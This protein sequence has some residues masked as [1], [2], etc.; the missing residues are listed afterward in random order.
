MLSIEKKTPKNLENLKSQISAF[1]DFKKQNKTEHI[2][3][4]VVI[5]LELNKLLIVRFLLQLTAM[6]YTIMSCL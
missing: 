3:Q 2:F 5:S 1:F 6:S 4:K